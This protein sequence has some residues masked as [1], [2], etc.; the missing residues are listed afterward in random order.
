MGVSVFRFLWAFFALVLSDPAVAGDISVRLGKQQD[1]MR[2]VFD[3]PTPIKASVYIGDA[4]H[5]VLINTLSGRI[6]DP[7]PSTCQL[8]SKITREHIAPHK[9]QIIFMSEQPLKVAK[10]FMLPPSADKP[11][12]YVID[13]MPAGTN[14]AA[15]PKNKPKAIAKKSSS[16]P[17][18]PVKKTIIVDAGHGGPDPGALGK[19]KTQEKEVTLRAARFLKSALLKTGRY[20]V[21]MTRDTDKFI[22]L[23]QRV[24]IGRMSQ[25]DLF[26]SLHADS[27]PRA[28]TRG[29]SVYTL[30]KVASD[31]EAARLAAKENKADLFLGI[32][33]DVELP[34]VAN[35]LIDLTKRETMNLSVKL[36]SQ[37][38]N[39]LTSHINLLSRTHRFANFAVLRTPD[40]P[41]VLVE[42][43]YLSNSEDERMLNSDIY[44]CKVAK[45]IVN[46]IDKY[47]KEQ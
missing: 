22:S 19:N 18:I 4:N 5:T 44:L 33:F 45:Q 38:K 9:S 46:A 29:L 39:T 34:E 32:D 21:V 41:A 13:I 36:A 28:S 7:L 47:Y 43:G 37:L 17:V 2:I 23:G 30:S 15:P 8:F 1:G 12:R 40:I 6:A 10:K 24:K 31:K 16:S 27:S 3:C 11:H 20:N 26:I 14:K 42:L 25:G 35:I